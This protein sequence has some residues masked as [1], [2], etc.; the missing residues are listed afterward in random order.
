MPLGKFVGFLPV[1]VNAG[2][3]LPVF[4]ED[5]YLPVLMLAPPIF[6]KLGAFACGYCFGHDVNI[7]I[8]ILARK[9]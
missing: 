7:S 3:P 5:S 9:Y 8:S 1:R 6:P 4:I 2:K